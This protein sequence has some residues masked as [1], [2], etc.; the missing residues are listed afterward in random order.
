LWIREEG[1]YAKKLVSRTYHL[2]NHHV[3]VV[4][5]NVNA[6]GI[7]TYL[8]V[9]GR[10]NINEITREKACVI[11]KK[12]KKYVDDYTLEPP[13]SIEDETLPDQFGDRDW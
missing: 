8:L 10:G 1:I 9:S 5:K 11:V 3:Y 6:K 4:R 7:K 12:R 13:M 2:I